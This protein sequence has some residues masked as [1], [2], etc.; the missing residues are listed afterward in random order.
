MK[1][2][3]NLF[4]SLAGA[5]LMAG[6]ASCINDLN[7]L[8][9][10]D[11]EV[12]SE[13]VFT[14]QLDNYTS[15]LAKI[16][17]GLAIGGNQGGEGDADIAGV[18]GGSQASF[19]RGLWN[20]QELASDEAHCCWG[21]AGVNDLNT[22][23]WSSGNVFIKGFYYRL[24]Y[25]VQLANAFLRET[26]DELLASRGMNDANKAI[27]RQ[28]R[29]EA[30]FHRALAYFYLLDMFRNVPFV[31]EANA[32]GENP[33]Q[34]DAQKVFG[35]I[36]TELKEAEEDLPAP[37]VGYDDA[38]Y[39]RATKA[40]AWA[41]LSR[42]YLNAETYVG[43]ARYTECITYSKKVIEVGY[44]LEPLYANLFKA[45][46]Q[47]SK[48]MI[49]PIRYEGADTQT[50]GGMTFLVC[51]TVPT[52]LKGDINAQDAWQG[53]RARVSLWN[54]FEKEGDV[55]KDSRFGMLRTDKTEN[56]EIVN[57]SMYPDNGIPVVKYVNLNSD[58]TLPAS[59]L[60]W[61][62]FPLFRLGEIYLNYAEAVLRGGQGGDQATALAYVNALRQRAYV[63][64][65]SAASI[66]A[67]GL[68]LQF[69]LDERAR[70]FFFEA[71]RRTDLARYGLL[72]GSDY[73]WTWKGNTQAGRSVDAHFGIYPLPSDEIG[74]NT[75][76]KQNAGYE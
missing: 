3:R 58:G 48:E 72:T 59:N 17:A 16:Y 75:N 7:T 44:V 53:N 29:A 52:A 23:T 74:S 70:E 62:D 41:L 11:S 32:V 61:I 38:G 50:W 76:L 15:A 68:T 46:N 63:D 36:E 13:N 14:D 42:L 35:Y 65:P 28:Y 9:L 69:I 12:V 60:V 33:Q 49:F 34:A 64:D 18:D 57:P 5:G 27:V 67:G 39:G 73:I 71:Q 22:L 19:L 43:A 26:T 55:A 31:T 20:L 2:I 37:F 45:D 6:M 40:A 10:A 1:T 8:P 4:F 25:Q 24:L 30:R 54:I 66:A 56:R 51:S 47:K 21:D